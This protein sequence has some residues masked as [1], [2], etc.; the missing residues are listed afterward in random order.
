MLGRGGPSGGASGGR[1][2]ALSGTG[3][4]SR[5][6]ERALA[7]G[8]GRGDA[9]P[10]AGGGMERKS[11]SRRG[12][13]DVPECVNRRTGRT[14]RSTIAAC[15]ISTARKISGRASS[16]SLVRNVSPR[17]FSQEED[18]ARRRGVPAA[19]YFNRNTRSAFVC[20]SI[21]LCSAPMSNAS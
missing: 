9:A 16:V 19:A 1:V 10:V 5:L 14:S 7:A 6:A 15:N 11:M 21:F 17:V 20:M 13:S 8:A 3:A 2:M 12:S 18:N 4:G